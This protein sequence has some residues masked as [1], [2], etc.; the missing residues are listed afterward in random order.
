MK[1][2][3]LAAAYGLSIETVR[4][5]PAAKR[6]AAIADIEAGVQPQVAELVAELAKACYKAS[7]Y[8]KDNVLFDYYLCPE[9]AQ[10]S[11]FTVHYREK[12]KAD[13]TYVVD[14]FTPLTAINLSG[15]IAKVEELCK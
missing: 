9:D 13:L 15:A 12:G 2:K 3:D 7:M 1:H 11:R 6:A 5:W 14:P 4:R 10:F 8:V